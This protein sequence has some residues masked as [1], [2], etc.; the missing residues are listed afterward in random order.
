VTEDEHRKGA[1]E[2]SETAESDVDDARPM[3]R[4]QALG[5]GAGVVAGLSLGELASAGS[6][7][8]AVPFAPSPTLPLEERIERAV[9]AISQNPA[10][11]KT[12]LPASRNKQVLLARLGLGDVRERQDPQ[13]VAQLL[14]M[15]ID[16]KAK[17]TPPPTPPPTTKPYRSGPASSETVVEWVGALATLAAG[18]LAA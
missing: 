5:A 16:A 18:A 8:P 17:A 4:R 2:K 15:I 9:Q 14:T 11:L 13:V 6:A 12:L 1:D 7:L 3:T 10:V